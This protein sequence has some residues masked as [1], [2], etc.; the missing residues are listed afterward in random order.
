MLLIISLQFGDWII[1]LQFADWIISLQ[2]DLY[3]TMF[4][5]LRNFL[6]FNLCLCDLSLYFDKFISVLILYYSSIVML[7]VHSRYY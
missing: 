1:S 5:I 6:H 7:F 2:L 3:V 4:L